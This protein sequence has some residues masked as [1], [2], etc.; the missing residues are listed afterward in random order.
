[1]VVNCKVSIKT[2]KTCLPHPQL[3]SIYLFTNNARRMRRYKFHLPQFRLGQFE[4]MG[5]QRYEEFE[6][7]VI[8]GRHARPVEVRFDWSNGARSRFDMLYCSCVQRCDRRKLY[9]TEPAA[10]APPVFIDFRCDENRKYLCINRRR[11]HVGITAMSCGNHFRLTKIYSLQWDFLTYVTPRHAYYRTIPTV[12]RYQ[13]QVDVP[14]PY[15]YV[16]I[17]GLL[18]VEK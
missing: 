10:K 5:Q 12:G 14:A 17:G 6:A 9:P 16:G 13:D 3:R 1:M 11:T 18:F 8:G 7:G 4:A 15:R 2:L